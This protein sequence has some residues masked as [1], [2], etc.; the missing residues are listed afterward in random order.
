M[1]DTP[2]IQ[3]DQRDELSDVIKK[4]N[5]NLHNVM[6]AVNIKTKQAGRESSEGWKIAIADLN[7]DI[8][9]EI[10][11]LTVAIN[12]VKEEIVEIKSMLMPPIGSFLYCSSN[13]GDY[14]PDTVW[15]QIAEGTALLASGGVYAPGKKYQLA[16]ST[17]TEGGTLFTAQPLWQR[18]K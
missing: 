4:T 2:L 12:E 5:T 3:L 8:Q 18:T 11:S 13:P 1:V 17:L 16:D 6:S 7:K 14:Y 15:T 9:K 10:S